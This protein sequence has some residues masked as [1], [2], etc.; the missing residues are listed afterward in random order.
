[1]V[2]N[3]NL[4]KTKKSTNVDVE[5]SEFSAESVAGQSLLKRVEQLV[6]RIGGAPAVAKKLSVT[7]AAIYKWIKGQARLPFC[8][9]YLLAKEA[10]VTLD[11]LAT[12]YDRRPDLGPGFEETG[13][14]SFDYGTEFIRIACYGPNPDDTWCELVRRPAIAVSHRYL[15]ELRMQPR[16]AALVE[17]EGEAME[18]EISAGDVLLVDRSVESIERDGVYLLFRGGKAHTRRA[19][20]LVEGSI[21]LIPANP[22][23]ERELLPASAR[24]AGE[25]KA[26]LKA[27][28]SDGRGR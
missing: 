20:L 27:F 19:R 24:V 18:R 10:D 16:D 9:M 13:A 26:V 22:E 12:G 4:Y 28:R 6:V 5:G 23:Y 25:V 1:M 21:Q 2:V 14:A 15:D 17:A 3:K 7:K 11:W 8:E